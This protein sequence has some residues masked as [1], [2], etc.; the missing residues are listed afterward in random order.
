[1]RVGMVAKVVRRGREGIS[2]WHFVR[3]L[4]KLWFGHRSF[5]SWWP[6]TVR[7]FRE[8]PQFSYARGSLRYLLV[9][10]PAQFTV[11]FFNSFGGLVPNPAAVTTYDDYIPCERFL[12][13][14][15]KV[16]KRALVSLLGCVL[17]M[18]NSIWSHSQVLFSRLEHVEP[19]NLIK[20]PNR[21]LFTRRSVFTYIL[22]ATITL[23]RFIFSML[24]R[25][26]GSRGT[27]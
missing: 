2:W 7:S 17:T 5:V 13:I 6:G 12:P 25:A 20:L 21:S 1:M 26:K 14:H 15:I 18:K 9:P 19:S 16:R 24:E 10:K 4:T 27:C 22:V 3:A 11:L 23:N 8:I